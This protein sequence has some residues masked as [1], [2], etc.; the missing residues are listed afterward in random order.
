[1][2]KQS[3]FN[4][5]ESV[6]FWGLLFLVNM[7]LFYLPD[8]PMSVPTTTREAPG[9]Q[10]P[11]VMVLYTP[12]Q[13]YDFL[14]RIEASGRAAFRG[15]HL[16]LDLAFPVIYSLFFFSLTRLL[17][18]LTSARKKA[19]SFSIFFALAFDLA[20]N[21]T[22]NIITA[23]YPQ[24][25]QVLSHLAQVFTLVKFALILFSVGVIVIY[26]IKYFTLRP[27]NTSVNN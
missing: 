1:M 26:L 27:D 21:L 2:P 20:E 23:R 13:L 9:L 5:K 7:A 25:S 6:I 16:T 24:P 8:F 4:R 15:M 10:I 3:F 12:D 17:M 11:D 19:L 18:R 22:L 14:T